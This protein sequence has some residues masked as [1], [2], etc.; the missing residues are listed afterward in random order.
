[1]KQLTDEEILSA[2]EEANGF[3][4]AAAKR[5]G[6]CRWTVTNRLNDNSAMKERYKEIVEARVDTAESKLM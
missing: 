3:I 4:G 6:C 1:M 2:L 5:L